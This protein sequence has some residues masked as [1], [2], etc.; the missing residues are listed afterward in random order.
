MSLLDKNW[1]GLLCGAALLIFSCEDPSEVGLGLDP[2]GIES[3]VFYEELILPAQNVFI[4]SLRTSGS[5]R[6]LVGRT[7]DD[8]FGTT[9]SRA[10][11]PIVQSSSLVG[12]PYKIDTV[13][14]NPVVLDTAWGSYV[15][16]KAELALQYDYVN[17]K[18]NIP[19]APDSSMVTAQTIRIQEINDKLLSGV[20]YM[21]DFETPILDLEEGNEFTFFP[22]LKYIADPDTDQVD[23]VYFTLNQSWT[24][25]LWE[26]LSDS[27]VNLSDEF[28]GLS[29]LSGENNTAIVGFN[30]DG[31]SAINVHYEIQIDTTSVVDNSV[32]TERIVYNDSTYQAKFGFQA[33]PATNYNYIQTDR[34]G[35]VIGNSIGQNLENFDTNDG[36]VYLH[37]AS[38]IY[39]KLD[40]S[41]LKDFLEDPE[42]QLVQ[43]S[44]LEF[45]L[46]VVRNTSI[47]FD[48]L[49]N[50]SDFS[51][52]MLY[53]GETG[54]INMSGIIGGSSADIFETGIF[55][56]V[57]NGISYMPLLVDTTYT[58]MRGAATY[59]AQ[60][61]EAKNILY[62][63]ETEQWL[64]DHLVIMPTEIST[65]NRSIIKSDGIKLKI[66]YSNPN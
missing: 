34:A 31:A 49:I 5:S 60:A 51:S 3:G 32:V 4:D 48:T 62:D 52:R 23:T 33:S 26:I 57:S 6:L 10:Y 65:V 47:N 37:H 64:L 20:Y 55:T 35:S 19:E 66:Y 11:F 25:R 29:L 13:S 15:L 44:N 24:D 50:P 21:S 36:Y 7:P 45:E 8:D 63:E 56:Y 28:K 30:L 12:I 38:G 42:N 17:T 22:R 39:P 16:K 9:V 14:L 40:L 43:I 53:I 46:P 27:E 2:D 58:K 54:H 41:P 59:F 61:V 18:E 1:T